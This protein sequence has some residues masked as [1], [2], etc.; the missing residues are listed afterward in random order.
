LYLSFSDYKES[1]LRDR[2]E[3]EDIDDEDYGNM[4]A[5]ARLIAEERMRRRDR[6]QARREG[7]LPAA[8]M[9][10]GKGLSA[11]QSFAT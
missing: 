5:E 7:R 10:D 4:S 11:N 6:E 2:Y 9:D 3:E 8:F 1:D